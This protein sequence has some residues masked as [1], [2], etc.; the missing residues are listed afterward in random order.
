MKA[1]LKFDMS[2]V[3]GFI[4]EHWEKLVLAGVSAW[5]IM[6]VVAAVGRE[7]LPNELKPEAI[8]Q[9]ATTAKTTIEDPKSRPDPKPIPDFQKTLRDS[10]TGID[11]SKVEIP[12]PYVPPIPPL[13]KRIDPQLLP[14][15]E[16]RV[17]PF[18]GAI[19]VM[20]NG[21]AGMPMPAGG[22][23][24]PQAP[25]PGA[26]PAPVPP[27]FGNPRNAPR[28]GGRNPVAPGPVAPPNPFGGTQQ[29]D[30]QPIPAGFVLPG[31][32]SGGN[33]G[34]AEGKHGVLVTG[35][36]PLLAQLKIYSDCFRN[37]PAAAATDPR[38]A[39]GAGAA[40][41][42]VPGDQDI[43]H[44]MWVVL[45]RTDQAT[46]ELKSIDFGD[47]DQRS[48]DV[49][50]EGKKAVTLKISQKFRDLF[51]D[52]QAWNPKMSE[53]ADPDCVGPW[54]LT[55][56]LPPLLLHDWGKEAVH[57]PQIPFDQAQPVAGAAGPAQPGEDED[58]PGQ[59][60][61][62]PAPAVAGRPP[63]APAPGFPGRRPGMG[64]LPPGMMPGMGPGMGPGGEMKQV[65]YQLFRYVDFDVEAGHTYQYKVKLVLRNPNFG[66]DHQFLAVPG[67]GDPLYRETPWSETSPTAAV[68]RD[69]DVLAAGV[70]R[71]NR[72]S[73]EPKAKASILIWHE[74]KDV[75]NPNP[76]DS[77]MELLLELTKEPDLVDLGQ[78]LNFLQRELKQVVDPV[79]RCVRDIKDPNVDFITNMALLG[80]HGNDE[81]LPGP[82][83]EKDRETDS[84]EL[85]LLE[86]VDHP[87]KMR[88]AV[89]NE[90]VD[91][92]IH[93]AWDK[94]HKV[95]AGMMNN[96][97]MPGPFPGA[98]IAPFPG[99]GIPP[100]K[101]GVPGRGTA[102]AP[103]GPP[104][105]TP[106]KA[107]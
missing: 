74:P 10:L 58:K 72:K 18:R 82:E 43:P 55:W 52:A 87:E 68:P 6:F 105:S 63:Q 15:T 16:L 50:S 36:V 86:N 70:H 102:P 12:P 100:A 44:Y 20:A 57:Y 95:P 64:R 45:E 47:W 31:P 29:P 4:G 75:N 38:A 67:T 9:K 27:P 96:P 39:G 107:K 94:T 21:G 8:N 48:L 90:S 5:L 30:R 37:A 97:G 71:S 1:K 91:Q 65:P 85:L 49:Q 33:V 28:P 54:W 81:K 104:G 13:I 78:V 3:K 99:N 11:Q 35:L 93:N 23:R 17:Y 60:G 62:A 56:Q 88:L 84:G 66:I 32:Q 53:I 2:G 25:L 46:G 40:A 80:Y 7:T 98:G 34:G 76:N 59:A 106:K 89:V 92:P 101:G 73:V 69:A 77:P 79:Q 51:T 103:Y 41:R 22:G 42:N 61:A 24:F 19:G 83:K 26:K 14:V